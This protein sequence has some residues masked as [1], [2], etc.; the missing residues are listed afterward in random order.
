MS[1]SDSDDGFNFQ[2]KAD[3]EA[4]KDQEINRIN[5]D[6]HFKILS[7]ICDTFYDNLQKSDFFNHKSAWHTF[8][9]IE[10]INIKI[11]SVETLPGICDIV[12]P[13]G[14]F[15]HKVLIALGSIILEVDNLLPNIGITSYESL[16]GLS[17]YGEDIDT[18]DSEKTN[19][20]EE[21]QI[22][23]ILP[24]LNEIK[25]KIYKLLTIAI[26]LIKQLASLYGEQNNQFYHTSYK[27]FTFDLAFEY[28]G[29]ILSYFLAIDTVVQQ[30]EYIKDHWDK[31]RT[32]LLQIKNNLSEFN[33]TEEQ[34]KKLDKL[35]KKINAPI[36]D[37]T[38]Y[39]QCI[40]ILLQR[41]GEVS[42]AGT[43][44]KPLNTCTVFNHHLYS[45]LTTKIKTIYSNLN[46]T[47]ESYEPIQ[48]FHY[49]SLFGFYL[50][51]NPSADNKSILKAVWQV[52]KKIASIP[53]VGISSFNI[54]SFL[55]GFKEFKNISLEPSNVTKHVK[56]EL[57][58]LEKQLPYLINTYNVKTISWTTKIETF[59]YDS[60]TFSQNKN[61]NSEILIDSGTK[62]AKLIIEGLCIANYLRK[63][64]SYILETHLN[65]G[66]QLTQELINSIT[67]GLELIKVI[68]SEF[69]KLMRVIGLNLNILNRALLSPIQAI[70]KKVAEIAQKKY[71]DGKSTN[72]ELYKNALSGC[73]IFYACSQAVQ[74]E[75]RLVIEKLIISTL[76]AKEMMDESSAKIL[77]ENIWMAELINQLSRE[78]KRCTDCSFLYLYQ[79]IIPTSYKYIYSD[80]PKRLYYFMMAVND[81]EKP[82]YYC[83]Y[84]ENDGIEMIKLLRKTSFETFEG[85]F[86][87]KL[88]K[89]IEDDIRV[90]VHSSF[91]EGL[92][93]AN[94]SDVNFNTYLNIKNFKFFDK[95]I[96]IRRYI[97]EHLNMNFYKLTTLN[98]NNAQTYQQMR[99]LAKHKFGLN[100][101]EVILPNQKLDQ[102]KDIL[103]I[104]R[105][106]GKFSKSY[107][108]NMHSQIFIEIN[109]ES[110]YINIIGVQQI[111]NSLY[112]HGKG[113]VNSIINK[114]FGYIS[115]TITNLLRILLDDY[116]LSLLKDERTFWDQNKAT[117]KYNYPLERAM[118]LRQKI[119][120]L[121]ENKVVNNI[122]KSIQFIT[123][124]GNAVALSRCIRTAVMDYNSQNVNLLTSYNIDDFNNL[125]QQLILQDKSDP[126]NPNTNISPEMLNN[127]QNSLNDSNK[128]FCDMISSLKQT[129]KNELNYLEI[130]IS[131]FEGNLSPEKIPDIDLF[132]FLLPPLTI[133]FIDNAIN[134]RDNL[135][136]KN[137]SE[138]M[139]Y[140]SDDG[141]MIGVCYLLKLFSA[142]KKFESLSWFPSVISYYNSKK[143][144]RKNEKGSHGVDTLNERQI[145]SYKEQFELQYFTYTSAAILFNECDK[146]SKEDK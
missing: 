89:E 25:D 49:L 141:F 102:G 45:F 85:Y 36:F 128:I 110:S 60:E 51:L 139:A 142:D 104:I 9:D 48:L 73:T 93:S 19:Q 98:L 33:M 67:S 109:S 115:K 42:P 97:E 87:K 118:S 61:S 2:S 46:T 23:R 3:F 101:H 8:S 15:Y 86:L 117:I 16:Y 57:A 146:N 105:N 144:Q 138:E 32:L 24:Y 77:N 30:N 136:K 140:F 68:E 58:A 134:A 79:N 70:L 59:F 100:L 6:H 125:V 132:A 111:I 56:S 91:I 122:T 40:Q 28:L 95:V 54:E 143:I 53:L 35:V 92:E 114:A 18:G 137:K 78:V 106:L 41:S 5:N 123:Q 44:I 96:S 76:S 29:K 62:K 34:R 1:D 39:K 52:Q 83:K 127:T 112:T 26:N 10:P 17:I 11:S 90:Q 55:N 12:K 69:N 65:L 13:N 88:A 38:C 22:S 103:E 66:T 64:I 135:L 82:L 81:I 21:A 108:H 107:T 94:Y 43:G 126:A 80:R 131:A 120:N 37:N 7:E 14:N 130:L 133:T 119:I 121:D 129:G 145:T 124:I 50:I 99:V 31:Y 84:R 113:I 74:S 4:Q 116:I 63:N 71:K 75:L 72:E 20:N 27:F 47:T